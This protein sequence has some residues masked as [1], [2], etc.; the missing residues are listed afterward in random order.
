MMTAGEHFLAFI[1]PEPKCIRI[2][3]APH[4]SIISAFLSSKPESFSGVANSLRSNRAANA[5]G[6]IYTLSVVKPA[7]RTC[8]KEGSNWPLVECSFA[9]HYLPPFNYVI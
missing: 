9:T 7:Q 3:Y 6:T 1:R 8:S 2:A 4:G 5:G